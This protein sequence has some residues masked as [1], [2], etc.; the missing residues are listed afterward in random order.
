MDDIQGSSDEFTYGDMINP[1]VS[2]MR[3]TKEHRRPTLFRVEIGNYLYYTS[4]RS[5][6]LSG[7]TL[8][9]AI[10][11]VFPANT[12]HLIEGGIGLYEVNYFEDVPNV[13]NSG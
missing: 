8:F 5:P 1:D 12:G 3:R 11:D 9:H 10:N 7:T 13:L 2:T 4:G 6:A